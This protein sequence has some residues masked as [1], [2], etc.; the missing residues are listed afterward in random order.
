M[1]LAHFSI[2]LLLLL[3]I[4]RSMFC[5][6]K[7]CFSFG[8][9]W[10]Y[11]YFLLSIMDLSQIRKVFLIPSC[12]N[13]CISPLFLVNK[14]FDYSPIKL[15]NFHY[16]KYVYKH[17]VHTGFLSPMLQI[18]FLGLRLIVEFL[19]QRT[20]NIKRSWYIMLNEQ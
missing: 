7:L 10:I 20:Q 13:S 18:I 17:S 1:S 3:P 8:C 5:Q 11:E 19:G 9:G 2:E 12:R 15:E 14:E 16:N 4:L 6:A